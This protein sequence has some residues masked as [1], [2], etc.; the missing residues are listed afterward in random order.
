M[1]IKSK[2]GLSTFAVNPCFLGGPGRVLGGPGCVLGVRLIS[3]DNLRFNLQSVGFE[4]SQVA[5]PLLR[6][7]GAWWS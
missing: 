1:E 7:Y 2:S 6:R 3:E 4:V 5:T